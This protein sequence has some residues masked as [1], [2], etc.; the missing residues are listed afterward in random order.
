MLHLKVQAWPVHTLKMLPI[1]T[2]RPAVVF[3][4]GFFGSEQ[5]ACGTLKPTHL[6]RVDHHRRTTVTDVLAIGRY[7]E[8]LDVFELHICMC[9]CAYECA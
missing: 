6:N 7:S 8:C 4:P 1:V 9:I 3:C 5:H 2:V